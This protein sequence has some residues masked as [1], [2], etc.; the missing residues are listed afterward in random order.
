MKSLPAIAGAALALLIA[1]IAAPASA[2]RLDTRFSCSATRAEDGERVIYSD[3][4]EVHLNGEHIESFRWESA[5]FRPTHGFDCSIDDGDQLQAELMHGVQSDTWRITLRDA[6][7]ARDARGYD[8]D[9]GLNCSIRLERDGATLSIKPSCPALCGSR[10]NFTQ[11]SVDLK[12]GIC[13]YVE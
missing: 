4:G 11:L 12:T 7:T 8:F 10:A 6:R 3:F 1:A 2:Q 13:D 9:R 5:L